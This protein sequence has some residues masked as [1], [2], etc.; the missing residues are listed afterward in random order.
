MSRELNTKQK[1]I[2]LTEIQANKET[3]LSDAYKISND[4]Y[5]RCMKINDHETFYQNVESFIDD[6]KQNDDDEFWLGQWQSVKYKKWKK[7][8]F[9]TK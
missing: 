4:V 5:F 7:G 2:I 1:Q 9:T 6:F 8:K 3:G